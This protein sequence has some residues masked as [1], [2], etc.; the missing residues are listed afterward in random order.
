MLT[1]ETNDQ[2]IKFN[3]ESVK[4][5]LDKCIKHW[6]KQ[7]QY[8]NEAARYYIDAYQSVRTNLFGEEGV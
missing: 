8:G 4:E 5:Y 2:N 7:K 3:K 1:L 6:R